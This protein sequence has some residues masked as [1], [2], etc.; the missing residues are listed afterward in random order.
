MTVL[1]FRVSDSEAV[2]AQEWAARL[3][4]DRSKPLRD[5]LRAH[6]AKLA[7]EAEA[8]RRADVGEHDDSDL[9]SNADWGPAEEWTGWA[10]AAG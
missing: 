6:L 5:A 3:G 10:D 1:R 9:A 7:S 8:L 4:V 2:A